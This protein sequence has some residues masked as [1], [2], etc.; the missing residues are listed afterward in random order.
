MTEGR[1]LLGQPAKMSRRPVPAKMSRRPVSF[2][3]LR[4]AALTNFS[5]IFDAIHI[6]C[7]NTSCDQVR[8]PNHWSNHPEVR[9]RRHVFD[10][11]KVD[12]R[13]IDRIKNMTQYEGPLPIPSQVGP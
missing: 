6:L 8:K 4:E 10:G 3:P 11:M 2:V 1:T 9:P 12:N 13:I 7:Y 5:R